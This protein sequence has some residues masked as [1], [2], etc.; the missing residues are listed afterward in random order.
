[1]SPPVAQCWRKI[2]VY[3]GDHSCVQLKSDIHCRNCAVFRDA[4]RGLL[5]R[6]ADPLPPLSTALGGRGGED[7][8]SVLAFRLGREWL[9]LRCERVAEVAEAR[10][11]RRIAHRSNGRLEGLVPV[12]G[13]L[14]LCV[15]LIE[16]L[17]LGQRHELAGE[18]AR[19][20]LLAPANAA[21]IAFRASEVAG[22]RSVQAHEIEEVPATL[23]PALARCLSG[24]VAGEH[25]RMALL[26]DIAVLAALEEALYA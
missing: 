26:D 4:A 6:E 7:S 22:L 23:P 24:V 2:G 14:H 5:L 16:V 17:Q 8:R 1:M 10:V 13:E 3:G 12:R 19:L 18:R 25:G 15:A 20:V 9:G 21:P 11:P